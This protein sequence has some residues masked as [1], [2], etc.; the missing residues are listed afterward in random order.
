MFNLFATVFFPLGLGMWIPGSVFLSSLMAKHHPFHGCMRLFPD[1]HP[2]PL[3]S[4]LPD[5]MALVSP[6]LSETVKD[7]DSLSVQNHSLALRSF[8]NLSKLTVL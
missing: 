2:W 5:L 6:Q 7:S 3:V 4:V 8:Y 1:P